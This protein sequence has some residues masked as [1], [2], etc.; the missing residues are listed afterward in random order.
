MEQAGNWRRKRLRPARHHVLMTRA[1]DRIGVRYCDYFM[2]YNKHDQLQ[3]LD[4]VIKRKHGLAVIL[5]NRRKY[6]KFDK[7]RKWSRSGLKQYEKINR[8]RKREYLE[9]KGIPYRRMNREHSSEEFMIIV[10][11]WLRALDKQ[12]KVL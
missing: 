6:T 2:F 1:L 8:D 7:S 11:N 10:R 4:I 5:W 12:D 9:E 3:Y